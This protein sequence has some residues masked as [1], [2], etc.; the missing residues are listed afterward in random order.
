VSRRQPLS[1]ER[2]VEAALR[3]ADRDGA[4]ALTMR[5]LGRELG[6]EGMAVY[7]YFRSKEELLGAVAGRV[8]A[9]LD[10]QHAAASGWQERVRHVI[11]SWKDL[12]DRHP[13]GFLLIYRRR[14][15]TP[16]ELAPIEELLGALREAG[17]SPA[18]SVLAYHVLVWMLDGI[19]LASSYGDAPVNEVWARTAE[20]VDL[21]GFPRLAEAAPHAA[22]VTARQI[23]ELGADLLVRG[24]ERL[25]EEAPS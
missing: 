22:Q 21:A 23:F 15:F 2:I 1:R 7:G 24:L 10:L 5:R 13:G 18:R 20:E 17:L 3:L 11:H 4:D 12:R 9:E 16:E 6:V 14:D 19:L 8:L 25:V